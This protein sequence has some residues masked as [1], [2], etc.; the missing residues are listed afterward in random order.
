MS[1]PLGALWHAWR[2]NLA[3]NNAKARVA[4][5]IAVTTDLDA[6]GM[7]LVF[8]DPD[9]N[10]LVYS[11]LEELLGDDIELMLAHALWLYDH[12][13]DNEAHKQLERAQRMAPTD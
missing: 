9:W 4:Q 3:D 5:A 7:C 13:N 6:L 8:E 10:Q 12:G 11:R 2:A 1:Q